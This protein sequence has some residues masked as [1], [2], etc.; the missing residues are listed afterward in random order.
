MARSLVAEYLR[1]HKQSI[2]DDWER[3]VTADLKALTRLDRGALLD[4]LPEVLDALAAFIEGG[5]D[6]A[7]RLYHAL[8]DGHAMQR[9]AFGVELSVLNIEYGWLR[10]VLLQRLL[11]VDSTDAVRADL[12]RLN[13]GL[14]RAI[15]A[16]V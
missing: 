2:A 14:D 7:E 3:A 1:S 11:S 4:H 9:L 8:A 5:A 15:H 6:E 13:E 16:A 10:R 12:I